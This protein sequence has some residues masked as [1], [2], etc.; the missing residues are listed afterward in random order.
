MLLTLVVISLLANISLIGMENAIHS[1]RLTSSFMSSSIALQRAQRAANLAESSIDRQADYA[2]TSRFEPIRLGLF[3]QFY[4]SGSQRQSS[5]QKI[6]K[7]ELCF[8]NRHTV[9]QSIGVKPD[10]QQ[11]S[12]AT[13]KKVISAYLIEQLLIETEPAASYYRVTTCGLGLNGSTLAVVQTI[14]RYDT[15][16]QRVSWQQLH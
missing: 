7:N 2:L 3:P 15:S 11:K 4:N 16:W 1:N 6:L 5:W 14:V 9:M 12:L 10:G 13:N 8:S